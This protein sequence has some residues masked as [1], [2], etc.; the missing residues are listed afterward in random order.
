MFFFQRNP[1]HPNPEP[2]PNIFDEVG[3]TETDFTQTLT[4]NLTLTLTDRLYFVIFLLYFVR[5]KY[6]F[7]T[8]VLQYLRA[9]AALENYLL[10][11]GLGFRWPKLHF[12]H[13]CYASYDLRSQYDSVWRPYFPVR[14]VHPRIRPRTVISVTLILVPKSN[15]S[16]KNFKDAVCIVLP[17]DIIYIKHYFL[18]TCLFWIL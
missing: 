11:L 14:L 17:H 3:L 4:L 5:G 2:N 13:T 6:I 15:G 7:C 9:R 18:V 8:E 1:L 10:G 12:T 16:S